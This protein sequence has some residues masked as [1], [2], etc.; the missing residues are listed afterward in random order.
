MLLTCPWCNKSHK[1]SP[2]A[3]L[4]LSVSCLMHFTVKT[5]WMRN[6][7]TAW[8]RLYSCIWDQDQD[9]FWI[10]NSGTVGLSGQ[11]WHPDRPTCDVTFSRQASRVFT[12][13]SFCLPLSVLHVQRSQKVNGLKLY[14]FLPV[15]CRLTLTFAVAVFILLWYNIG[16]VKPNTDAELMSS[17]DLSLVFQKSPAWRIQMITSFLMRTYCLLFNSEMMT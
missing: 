7:P 8:K 17:V 16:N 11:V 1:G 13:K 9:F 12:A 5:L 2:V 4:L 10:P 14:S 6:L 3:G 15:H